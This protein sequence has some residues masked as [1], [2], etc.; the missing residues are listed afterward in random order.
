MKPG[1]SNCEIQLKFQWI[2]FILLCVASDIVSFVLSFIRWI[3]EVPHCEW[4]LYPLLLPLIKI[5]TKLLFLPLW[6]WFCFLPYF[7]KLIFL[8]DDSWSWSYSAITLIF[9]TLVFELCFILIICWR[10]VCFSLLYFFCLSHLLTWVG[11][12]PSHGGSAGST[13]SSSRTAED[14]VLVVIGD[15]RERNRSEAGKD[16]TPSMLR[17][18]SNCPGTSCKSSLWMIFLQTHL[19]SKLAPLTTFYNKCSCLAFSSRKGP[20]C[21]KS[22]VLHKFLR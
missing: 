9:F 18:A 5:K 1:V 10:E 6:L 13:R 20:V 8:S 16:Q 14:R 11:W 19:C 2:K 7:I 17:V 4:F 21:I 12:C 15:E 22:L 3:P